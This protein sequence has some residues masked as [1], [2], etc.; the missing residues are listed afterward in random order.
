M[1]EHMFLLSQNENDQNIK[2]YFQGVSASLPI[3]MGYFP[4]AMAFGLAAKS[5]GF[6]SV[7]ASVISVLIF[8]GA[9]QF[10]L[11]GMIAGGSSIVAAAMVCFA[12]N[13]R[14][15]VYGPS[16]STKFKNPG[17]KWLSLVSFGLTDEVFSTALSGLHRI[18]GKAQIPW[19]LGLETGAYFTWVFATW[20][21]AFSGDIIVGHLPALEMALSFSLP[22]LFLTL[23][24]LMIDKKTVIPVLVAAAVSAGFI[25]Y[26]LSSYTIF[27]G[28]VAGPVIW[29]LIRR[30]K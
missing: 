19:L 8:A 3:V 13:A 25:K 18:E 27:A 24:V 15:L 23:L 16:L 20:L 7:G 17:N 5:A 6:S 28:A 29:L 21:G 14:H 9:S 2:T 26:N 1:E 10:A 22:A 12:L 30:L 4:V 11:V